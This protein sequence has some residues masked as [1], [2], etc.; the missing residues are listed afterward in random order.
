MSNLEDQ[1]TPV[2]SNKQERDGSEATSP[3]RKNGSSAQRGDGP[4]SKRFRIMTEEEEYKWSLPQDMASYS[5]GCN[6]INW[7][8]QTRR[9]ST[10]EYLNLNFCNHTKI[11]TVTF[12][13]CGK[14]FY[15]LLLAHS[16]FAGA[17]YG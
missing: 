17:Y 9:N 7:L 12:I 13:F 15:F 1:D 4:N 16:G 3:R 8:N 10:I 5:G 6:P 2:E 11:N 14:G